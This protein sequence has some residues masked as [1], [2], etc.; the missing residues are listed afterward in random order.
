MLKN[1]Y[2]ILGVN[3]NSTPD[4]IEKAFKDADIK[5]NAIGE[6]AV[7]SQEY[8]DIREAFAILSQPEIKA[9]YDKELKAYQT[10]GNCDNYVIA[11]QSL[12]DY[13]NSLRLN[14]LESEK[15]KTFW[16]SISGNGCLLVIVFILFLFLKSCMNAIVKQKAR[17]SMRNDYSYVMYV[18]QNAC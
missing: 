5:Y 17:N 10:S 7:A 14:M 3:Y 6:K 8:Q 15:K 18:N 16:H 13:V 11:D 12:S 4:D 1:Y 2:I 9:L